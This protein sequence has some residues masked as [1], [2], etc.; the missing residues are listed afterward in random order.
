MDYLFFPLRISLP[1]HSFFRIHAVLTHSPQA[2]LFL[3]TF[4]PDLV[5]LPWRPRLSHALLLDIVFFLHPSWAFNARWFFLSSQG[6]W[7][8]FL[9]PIFPLSRFLPMS[10]FFLV[11][12]GVRWPVRRTSFTPPSPSTLKRCPSSPFLL[13]Q[14][15][16]N[17]RAALLSL[18][19]SNH[20]FYRFFFSGSG[21]IAVCN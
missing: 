15:E 2:G 12:Q 9:P 14:T 5:Y 8:T 16:R 21:R 7:A 20:R 17:K 4:A 18:D 19:E 11:K 10:P 13:L 1:L 3:G 6:P